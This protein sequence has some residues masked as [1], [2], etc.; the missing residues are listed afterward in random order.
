ML[1][2]SALDSLL[3]VTGDRGL[4]F[5]SKFFCNFTILLIFEI[6]VVPLLWMFLG[7]SSVEFNFSLFLASLFVGSWGLAAIGT[8]LNGIT[9][10]LPSG[11]LLFPI[12]MFP[13][14][15]PLLIGVILCT[16]AALVGGG[17]TVL[18]W[19]YFLLAFDFLFTIVPLVV[20]D[21]VLEG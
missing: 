20:F 21:Y 17:E 18:G 7:V 11:R 16:H 15:V 3:L 8:M 4:I 2:R 13:L 9:I 12:L 10:Q 5:L 14:L 19:L 6:L 1:F